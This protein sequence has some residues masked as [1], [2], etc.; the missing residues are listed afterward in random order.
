MQLWN[1]PEGS[2]NIWCDPEKVIENCLVLILQ[3]L[4]I[5]SAA[6]QVVNHCDLVMPY[7]A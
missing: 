7:V 6:I 5:L 1:L 3:K 4:Y 2:L